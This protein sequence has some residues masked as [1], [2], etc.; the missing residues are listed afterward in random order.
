MSEL[1]PIT[2][3]GDSLA[4]LRDAPADVSDDA[5]YQLELV[6]RGESPIDFK[7]IPAVGPGVMEI[8]VHAENEYRVFYLARFEEAVYV[9]HFF[10]KKTQETRRTDLD[11]GRRRYR[12]VLEFRKEMQGKQA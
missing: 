4:R 2:W 12:E 5:G 3:M 6:Q 11:A 1:K 9:L 8:R 10:V 7:P